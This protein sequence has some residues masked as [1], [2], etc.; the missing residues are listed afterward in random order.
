MSWGVFCDSIAQLPIG[1]LWRH[2]QAG[3][4][5]GQGD[6]IDTAALDMLVKANKGKAGWTYT[7]KPPTRSNIAA[8]RRANKA[9]FTVNLSGNNL[10]HADVLA[11][12][13]VGPVVVVLPADA[14]KNTVT[15]AG[16][17]VVVCPATIRDDVTCATCRLCQRGDRAAII[18][19]PAH[20]ASKRKAEASAAA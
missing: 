20:G 9:G 3:D 16:R 12:K 17:R 11:D 7:H 14:T 2:Y 6:T 1:T 19:F 13:K 4:L 15:P 18:G 5:P 8:I 10:A